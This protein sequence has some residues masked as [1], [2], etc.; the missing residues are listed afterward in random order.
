MEPTSQPNP[1]A[2]ATTTRH[3]LITFNVTFIKSLSFALY[4]AEFVFGLITWALVADPRLHGGHYSY[5]IFV[6]VFAWL[7]TIVWLVIQV[8][9]FTVQQFS[10]APWAIIEFIYHCFWS[11][12]YFV[13]AIIISVDTNGVP[14]YQAAAAF[15]WFTTFIYITHTL[16]SLKNWRGSFP[17]Q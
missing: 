10:A 16:L 12:M 5:V 14:K 6:G 1:S 9:G 17:W 3:S 7:L 2:T 13:A 15:S 8:F 11:I 4:M